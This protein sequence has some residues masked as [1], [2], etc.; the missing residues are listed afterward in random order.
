MV[1]QSTEAGPQEIDPQVVI[2]R[3]AIR[4]NE[5]LA[6]L[7]DQVTADAGDTNQERVGI[8]LVN[9]ARTQGIREVVGKIAQR[10]HNVRSAGP[11]GLIPVW[12]HLGN[13]KISCKDQLIG[14]EPMTELS[15]A[16]DN[17]HAGNNWVKA[18]QA[19][20]PIGDDGV[21]TRAAPDDRSCC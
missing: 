16:H 20:P 11:I 9:R 18:S 12:D 13:R 19:P 5:D 17:T 3:R 7:P 14:A 8:H 6:T 4:I 2:R 10:D 15:S 21:G 1:E